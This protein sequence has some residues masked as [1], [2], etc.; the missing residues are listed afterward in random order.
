LLP[1][2]AIVAGVI[3]LAAGCSSRPSQAVE[4]T[5]ERTV[6][7]T[8]QVIETRVVIETRPVP[9]TVVVTATP[10]P[11]PAYA[12]RLNAPVDTLSIAI[13]SEPATLSPQ[14]AT[15]DTSALIAQQLYEGLFNLRGDG[16]TVPAGALSY[17]ASGDGKVYT[18]TLRAEAKWSDGRPVTA[19]HFVDGICRALEPATGNSYYYL[20]TDI[21]RIT[22]AKA[23]ASGNTADCK[24]VGVKAVDERTLQFS[25]EQ[26]ASFFPKL[27]SMQIFFPARVDIT[28]TV[29]G[30]L[31]NNGPYTLAERVPGERIALRANPTYWNP[32]QV[33]PKRL[34]F[35]VV[36]DLA[37][38]FALYKQGELAVA[39]FP[40]ESTALVSG[41]PNLAKELRVLVRPGVS[42]LGL[43]T[44]V[45]PTKNAAFRKAIASAIDR[46]KLVEEVLKQRWHMP[47]QSVV[48]PDIPGSQ[49]KDPNAGLPY[50]LEAARKF[51]AEAGY[52]PD[53]PVPPVEFWINREGNN[54][55]LFR[56]VA[57]MLEKAGIPVRL[58]TSRWPIYRE[59]LEA[60]GSKLKRA[61][62]PPAECD[63]GIYRMGWVMD[64]ADP[65]AL[66]DIVFNPKSAFQYTGW[67]SKKYEDLMTQ[68]LAEQNEA[69]RLDLYRAA[70]KVLL[71]EEAVVVPLQ[72]Y[73][74]TLLV[75][76]GVTFDYPLFGA[77]NLQY[78]KRSR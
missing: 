70:E 17:K 76:D 50:N 11:T 63:F 41:D 57:D 42:Y 37:D 60:C 53:K 32:E 22:G 65:S 27:L 51:L 7:V 8:A 69:R 1:A 20:L 64:Y 13:A 21:A 39:E 29:A 2:A 35:R 78:W 38:Q 77:P 48:P 55:T 28:R 15:D 72:Y 43:N 45:G 74:R 59:A 47:A 58:N 5:V 9:Q 40:S 4:K 6:V 23:F 12:S 14:A 66:L 71:N 25:L 19:Q 68:A 33:G 31:V 52:G 18:V 61:E 44:Q 62:A 24:K 10:S 67:Q 3:L 49:A 30:G 26:P 46:K 16:S 54:E 36:P 56:A 75:K 34:E 73:D